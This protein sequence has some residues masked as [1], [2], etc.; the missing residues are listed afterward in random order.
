MS[1]DQREALARLI[2]ERR[3]DYAG[4]SRLIGRNPAY[5]Q[6]F[7]KRGVPK[8][9]DEADRRLLARYFGVDE[10]AL[11]GP[12]SA[13][14]QK[15]GLVA[16]PLLEVE[17]SAGPGALAGHERAVSHIGFD[18]RWLRDVAAGAP[19]E[20]SL[21]TV[22]GDSMV[23]TIAQGDD[24]LV[25]RS[26]PARRPRDG[27]YVIRRDEALLVKRI[28]LG[29]SAGRVTVRSDNDAYPSW[30]DIALHEIE[31]IGRVVWIGRKLR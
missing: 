11:G 8:K 10:A 14:S 22:R 5:I 4:L 19:A 15:A 1:E 12:P 9:L 16:V 17:A 30:P 3:E 25:D 24:I 31:V 2:A 28:A 13:P 18:E 21:I 29:P 20:L 7:I 23:P 6:Q 26:A 27:I